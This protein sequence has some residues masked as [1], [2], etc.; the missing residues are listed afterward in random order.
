MVVW[1]VLSWLSHLLPWPFWGG[2]IFNQCFSQLGLPYFS[3]GILVIPH[4]PE[5]KGKNVIIAILMLIC[6]AHSCPELLEPSSR[7][8][9]TLKKLVQTVGL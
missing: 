6:I 9:L 5:V 7:L 3:L 8:S 4:S 1:Q 2:S